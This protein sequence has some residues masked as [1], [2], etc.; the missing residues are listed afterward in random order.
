MRGTPLVVLVDH[1]TASYAEVM[2]AVLQRETGAR[3]V[4]APTAGN[5]ETIYAYE[6]AGGARLWVAQDPNS[7][8][9]DFEQS[10]LEQ[11]LTVKD[12]F[13]IYIASVT[14]TGTV[15]GHSPGVATIT[16]S[17]AGATAAARVEVGQ[18]R[19]ASVTAGGNSTCAL[20]TDGKAF[21]WGRGRTG[22]LGTGG[23]RWDAVALQ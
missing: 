15:T 13:R 16:A 1:S 12:S 8:F 23:A 9:G 19:F 17:A 3:V 11:V 5:T 14:G 18:L 6:L 7:K 4:G 21:C 22:Q 2:A 20:T 10:E